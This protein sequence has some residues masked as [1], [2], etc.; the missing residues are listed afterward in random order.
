[1][2]T[3]IAEI[4]ARF[5]RSLRYEDLPD[6]VVRTVKRTILDTV[7]CAIGGYQTAPSRI[8]IS[9]AAQV[10][11]KR[12]ATVF[13]SGTETSHDL[14]TF[15]NGVMIRSLDFNDAYSTPVG[16]GHPSDSL[17]ALIASA[18][19]AGRSGRDL[20]L[21]TAITYE[22]F[23][24]LS[25]VLQIKGKGIDQATVLGLASLVGSSRLLSLTEEQMLNAIG[26]TVGGNTALNQ[27]RVGTLSNW[28]HYATAEASR[29]AIFS[30]Q[31]AQAGMTG[32]REIFEGP[33]GFFQ[34]ITRKAIELPPLGEPFG[35]M[36]ATIKRFPLGQYAQ[37]VAD[38][39][40]QARS[41]V[42]DPSDIAEA[43]VSVS[44]N[45]IRVMAG[46]PAKWNPTTHETADHSIPYASA[47]ILMYGTIDDRY[48][49][50]RYLR[51]P[52]L[53]A[54][55][56]RVRCL[57]SEEADAREKECHLCDLELVLKSGERKS[58]RVEHTRGHWQNP[59][60]DAEMAE[61][62]RSLARRQLAA[63]QT[64]AL[65]EQLWDLENLP[66]AGALPEMTRLP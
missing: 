59:M 42:S 5:A 15:A 2:T 10:T 62:F 25:D 40:L 32:P 16:G 54:L 64:E 9:L 8:A 35:I 43:N 55:V 44:R 34:V 7:G 17:A 51:D 3:S 24:K 60:S 12:G 65:L 50:E 58:V 6:P 49:D 28:K 41:F 53:L 23:C 39:A 21:A 1:V 11:S 47:V 46:S 61:K 57:P 29:K 19:V 30:A 20:I 14:A 38:A 48:Y 33:S 18:E 31:L 66:Q 52:D 63:G 4:I 45:A 27:G 37:S 22:V 13:C 56:K 36:R 26:I